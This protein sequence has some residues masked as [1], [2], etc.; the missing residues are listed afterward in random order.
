M[1]A[2]KQV[3]TTGGSSQRLLPT[4]HSSLLK[5]DF[6]QVAAEC[7]ASGVLASLADRKKAHGAVEQRH[8][9]TSSQQPVKMNRKKDKGFESPRPFKL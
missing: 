6:L 7:E 4:G 9:A 8:V 5:V 2:V 1:A 3:E